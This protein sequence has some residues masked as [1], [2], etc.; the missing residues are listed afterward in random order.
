MQTIRVSPLPGIRNKLFP[1]RWRAVALFLNTALCQQCS[2]RF[3]HF[4]LA[5]F[6][7]V[8]TLDKLPTF[9][10]LVTFENLIMFDRLT[11]FDDLKTF[12][13]FLFC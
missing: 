3:H 8:A 10:K 11:T 13:T 7:N 5:T 6:D 1:P 9:D 12:D 2:M 4:A